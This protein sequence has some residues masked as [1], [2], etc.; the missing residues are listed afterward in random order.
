MASV[1][2][3]A[4]GPHHGDADPN[5]DYLNASKGLVVVAR[6]R[7]ITS[8]SG[9]CTSRSVLV[10]FALGGIFALARPPRASHARPHDHGRG[11]LQPHVH[12]PRR[13]HGVPLHHPVGAGGDGE[14]RP[15]DSARREGRRVPEAEPASLYIYVFGACFALWSMIHGG[16]DTG[17]TFYT[18]YSTIS[19]SYVIPM[20]LGAFIMGFSS[21]LTGVNFIATIHKMRA[22]GMTWSRLPLFIWALYA[23]SIMQVLATPVLA[24][25]LFLL[26]FERVRRHRDL[27]PEARRRP[28][29]LPALLLV[30]LAPG[31]LHHDRAGHGHHLASSSRRSRAGRSSATCSSP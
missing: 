15:P 16:V 23:T 30:L 11:H 18:P 1:A 4:H 10:A 17:W 26:T 6:P 21:I 7:S 22:P 27:R 5:A 13:G 3:T 14:L 2:T 29:A 24:I 9:S 12:A 19:N 20:M 28:R 25:T 8:G 31:R